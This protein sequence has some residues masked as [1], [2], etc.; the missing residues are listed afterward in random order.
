MPERVTTEAMQPKPRRFDSGKDNSQ[1]TP[2]F[3]NKRDDSTGDSPPRVYRVEHRTDDNRTVVLAVIENVFPH[4]DT[5]TQY[6]SRL[7]NEQG[8]EPLSG[9]LVLVEDATDK[10]LARR[11]LGRACSGGKRGRKQKRREQDS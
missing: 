4:H 11:D 5:L 1:M 6:V 3:G 9:E 7:L 2:G 8:D 10:V